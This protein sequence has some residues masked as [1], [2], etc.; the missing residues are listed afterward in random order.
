MLY[1]SINLIR[2][3]ADSRYTLVILAAKRA[4]DIIDGKPK[5]TEEDIEKPVSIA[6]HEIA[7]DL[8]TYHREREM[9]SGR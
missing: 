2:K 9:E 7:E 5:L 1:P 4:R 3:K 8:I 6:A